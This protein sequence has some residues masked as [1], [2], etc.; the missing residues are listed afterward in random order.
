METRHDTCALLWDGFPCFQF[1]LIKANWEGIE[2]NNY[3]NNFSFFLW[4]V[5]HSNCI[6]VLQQEAWSEDGLTVYYRHTVEWGQH[7]AMR[8]YRPRLFFTNLFSEKIW[9]SW[10]SPQNMSQFNHIH[11]TRDF[12]Q[13]IQIWSSQH[14]ERTFC[15]PCGCYEQV[16][17]AI[18]LY[19]CTATTA[20]FQILT[21]SPS[22]SIFP[23][24]STFRST[25]N[26][27]AVRLTRTYF[28]HFT[29]HTR[30]SAC[31]KNI[32]YFYTRRI[33]E[34]CRYKGGKVN[35]SCV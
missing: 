22:V 15:Y 5:T 9:K 17:A 14:H 1:S 20:S 27:P 19:T 4:H 10:L 32:S 11:C 24:H 18:T 30:W 7:T 25:V 31:R 3:K 16:S 34:S 6:T 35:C 29:Y 33:K 8:T 21:Y 12:S 26:Q 2:V 28:G 23:H 13:L